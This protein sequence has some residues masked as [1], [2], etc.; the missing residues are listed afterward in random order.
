MAAYAADTL[1]PDPL[2]PPPG[3][4]LSPRARAEWL[5]R[6]CQSLC[7]RQELEVSVGGRFPREVA[8]YVSN[9]LGYVDPLVIC[10]LTPCA[11]IA[12][13]EVASWPL[14]GVLTRQLNVIFVRRGDAPAGARALRAVMRRLE[15]GVSVLN[16]PEGT[17]TRGE[18][19]PFQR[20]VFGIAARLGVPVVPLAIS[21][22]APELCWVDDDSLVSHYT[23]SVL[24]TVHRV[25]LDVG[26]ALYASPR[27]TPMEFAERVR[28]WIAAARSRCLRARRWTDT[29]ADVLEGPWRAHLRPRAQPAAWLAEPL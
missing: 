7:R 14:L 23:R 24:G 8:I 28:S 17:T 27:E 26:P 12:K 25:H 19:L 29:A 2:E 22:R 4:L 1:L 9:H 16:F 11:P 10:S 13:L 18:L 3:S 20:G 15:A 5:Q 6:L 21:F